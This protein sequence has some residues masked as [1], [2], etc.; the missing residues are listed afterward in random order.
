[1]IIEKSNKIELIGKANNGVAGIGKAKR[2][3]PNIV[4]MDIG[5]PDID[6]IE[7][8]ITAIKND[9]VNF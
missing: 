5:L 6:G 8:T 3:N 4:L 1:M 7:A 2:I 9:I